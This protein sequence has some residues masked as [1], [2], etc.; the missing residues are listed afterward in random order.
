[1]SDHHHQSLN[2]EGHWGTTDDFATSFLNFS[3]FSIA[4]WD[5]PNSRPVHSL[6]VFVWD[7]YYLAVAPHFHGLYSSFKLCCEGP[8]FTSIQEEGC[9]K[10]THQSGL[11]AE[12]NTLV[13]PNW[14]Q[15]CQCCCCLYYLGEYLRLGTLISYNWTQVLEACDCLKLVSIY[16]NL[17]WFH[18]CLSSAW[19]SRHWSPCRR[20]W[21]LCRDAQ[22]ILPA[23]L[24]LL[25]SHRCHQRSGDWW[26]FCL[27]C[28]DD[29]KITHACTRVNGDKLW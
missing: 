7:V 18:W 15:S 1:M 24:P 20:L 5:L 10:G 26:L 25:L 16:F 11:G 14:F 13:T 2:R 28:S 12:R 4:L 23:L 8:W 21:R 22:L 17:C 27:Q 6:M 9:D 29:I 3:L 19:S